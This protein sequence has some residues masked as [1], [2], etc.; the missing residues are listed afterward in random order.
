[1]EMIIIVFAVL[2]AT[3]LERQ[4]E[5]THE[6]K[7]VKEFLTGL[8]VDLRN[9][10]SEMREDIA[11]YQAQAKWFTYFGIEKQLNR[12]TV[13]KYEWLIWNMI[14]LLVNNSRYEG[15]K[16]IGKIN[17]IENTEL[18][19]NILDLYQE[20]LVDLTNNTS[21]YVAMKREFHRLIYKFR[22]DEE[23]QQDN[24]VN[25]LRE[26]EI[27]DFYRRLSYANEVISRY[28][29]AISKSQRII[30][31]IDREYPEK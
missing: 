11:G 25:L 28:E 12:D 18:R 23:G 30:E 31:M 2:L 13:K 15:F 24:L 16:A 5:H 14:H 21:G 29:D 6:Q 10:I 9:D 22:E 3:F 17:T 8:R 26:T 19:N 4:R 1:M 20:T 27:R 7:E